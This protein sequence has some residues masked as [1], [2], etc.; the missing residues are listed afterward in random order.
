[1]WGFTKYK[2]FYRF[3]P[4]KTP[5]NFL[6][7][8]TL[9]FLSGDGWRQI[10]WTAKLFGFPFKPKPSF[11]YH[12]SPLENPLFSLSHSYSFLLLK[13]TLREI[14]PVRSQHVRIISAP[15]F[16]RL[17]W[18]NLHVS[19]LSFT[20]ERKPG[21]IKNSFDLEWSFPISVLNKCGHFLCES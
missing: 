17:P 7:Q 8:S 9:L 18:E 5:L 19:P 16:L 4:I 20:T 2:G 12:W 6:Q 13:S 3:H 14:F 10:W 21:S 1:M 15:L 11:M